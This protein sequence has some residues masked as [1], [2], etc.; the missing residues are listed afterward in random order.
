MQTFEH[1]FP[2]CVS[3]TEWKTGIC[4]N[5]ASKGTWIIS[6]APFL[7]RILVSQTLVPTLTSSVLPGYASA[8]ASIATVESISRSQMSLALFS[9]VLE[10]VSAIFSI[11]MS[12]SGLYFY[13]VWVVWRH[14]HPGLL[15]FPYL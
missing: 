3:P 14:S 2:C 4:T 10:V 9:G 6:A 11:V 5:S 8:H 7:G 13:R 12:M 15:S 1:R